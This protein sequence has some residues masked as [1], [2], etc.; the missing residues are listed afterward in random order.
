MSCCT[1]VNGSHTSDCPQNFGDTIVCW[2]C[3]HAWPSH[4]AMRWSDHGS[5]C[6][7]GCSKE[8]PTQCQCI[9]V[10]YGRCVLK[11]MHDGLHIN[12]EGTTW[13]A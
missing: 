1:G 6:L 11:F 12:T 13:S 7:Y 9:A 8:T 2:Q 10:L 3:G 5:R 4:Y